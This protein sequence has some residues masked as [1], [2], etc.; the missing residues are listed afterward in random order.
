MDRRLPENIESAAQ[1]LDGQHLSEQALEVYSLNRM[2]SE[3]AL[4]AVEEH[5]LCCPHCVK[6]LENFDQFHQAAKSSLQA[7]NEK[8]KQSRFRQ[9]WYLA[10]A[11]SVATILFVSPALWQNTTPV[12]V[13]LVA[14]RD[15]TQITAPANRNLDL[16]LDLTGLP[17]STYQWELAAA[18]GGVKASGPV[19]P[20]KPQVQ[21]S[22][23]AEG[24][25]WL[26]IKPS[27]GPVVREF[28]LSVR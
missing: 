19:D 4:A 14:V 16:K 2:K 5:L 13:D 18:T 28:S 15:A 11:A 1:V 23:Q 21:V 20:A 26:R 3:E 8:P 17:A 7:A 6:R 24:Q 22:G 12:A 10:L 9:L 27:S 25:Y